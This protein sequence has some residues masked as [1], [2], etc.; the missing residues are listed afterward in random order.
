DDP[1]EEI[2][3][4]HLE[5]IANGSR[6][7]IDKHEDVAIFVDANKDLPYEKWQNSLIT[8]LH[9]VVLKMLPLQHYLKKKLKR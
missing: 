4:Y 5:S 1:S 3:R 8:P 2:L 7:Q 6:K 9:W